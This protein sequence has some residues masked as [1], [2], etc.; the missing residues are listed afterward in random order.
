MTLEERV[1]NPTRNWKSKVSKT[2]RIFRS[3]L[4]WGI[5][6]VGVKGNKLNLFILVNVITN[7]V[8]PHWPAVD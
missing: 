7:T 5:G 3:S 6:L 8:N 2:L 4:N 1:R